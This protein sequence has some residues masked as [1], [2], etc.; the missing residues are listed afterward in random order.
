MRKN[1]TSTKQMSI[2]KRHSQ[3]ERNEVT[4]NFNW[5]VQV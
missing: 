4:D 1:K 2:Q 5:T 3:N